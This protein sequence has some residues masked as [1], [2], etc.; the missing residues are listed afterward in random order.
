MQKQ[1]AIVAWVVDDT[2]FVKKGIHSVGVTPQYCGQ[3]GE[4][5]NCRVGVSLSVCTADASL[6]IAWRLYLPE[7]WTQDKRRR[8]ATGVPEEVRFQTKPQIALQ[9]IRTAVDREITTAPVL[10]DAAYGNDTKFREGITQL[11]LLD[12]VGVQSSMSVWRP[13][14][15]PRGNGKGSDALPSCYAGIANMPPSRLAR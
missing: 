5:E 9:Q 1:A 3:V 15:C 2:G 8:E 13:G 11:G 12:A 4:Q 14:R 10:A 7:V 6:P